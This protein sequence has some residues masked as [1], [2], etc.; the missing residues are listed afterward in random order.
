MYVLLVREAARGIH[1]IGDEAGEP[2]PDFATA[3]E[4]ARKRLPGVNGAP[5]PV[6]TCEDARRTLFGE[7]A[8]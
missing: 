4:A 2:F 3:R 6:K 5:I 8:D 7:V 1:V